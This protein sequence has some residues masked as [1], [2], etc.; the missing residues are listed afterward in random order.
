MLLSE[1]PGYNFHFSNLAE[2]VEAH[3]GVALAPTKRRIYWWR[4]KKQRTSYV[5]FLEQETS[6][7]QG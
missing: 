3:P 5:L 4:L 1:M 6:L 7:G 2:M